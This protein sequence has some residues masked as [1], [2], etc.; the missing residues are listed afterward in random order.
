M[1]L[2]QVVHRLHSA[3]V[4]STEEESRWADLAVPKVSCLHRRQAFIS[5]WLERN[6]DSTAAEPLGGAGLVWHTQLRTSGPLS[7]MPS[8]H[9]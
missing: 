1:V 4:R 8:A 9:T 2:E 5:P 3:P 6:S 7:G